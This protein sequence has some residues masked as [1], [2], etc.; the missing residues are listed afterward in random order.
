MA[1]RKL[2][3]GVTAYDSADAWAKETGGTYEIGADG[4]AYA[5]PAPHGFLDQFARFAPY[6]IMA[7]MG[8]GA[9]S[10]AGALG[11]AA[12][13]GSGVAADVASTMAV[14]GTVGTGS[15]IGG[16]MAS[17]LARYGIPMAGDFLTSMF[18]TSKD[19]KENQK[20]RDF[21]AQQNEL[22]RLR[23]R[24][25]DQQ[26]TAVDESKLDP[27]RNTMSQV[28][29]ASKLDRLS[30]STYTPVQVSR[31]QGGKIQTSG[32]TTYNKSPE[33]IAAARAAAALILSGGGQAPSMTDPAN[34]GKT[35]VTDLSGGGRGN[36]TPPGR[37]PVG[38]PGYDSSGINDPTRSW[39][40][41]P[42]TGLRKPPQL[43]T[44]GQYVGSADDPWNLAA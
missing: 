16:M 35:G 25:H 12:G 4:N 41:D 27:W 21:Y 13:G 2:P 6:G 34:Y 39:P 22:D 38:P 44:P 40:I 28:G 9:L 8:Y 15:A 5:T 36:I 31:G 1:T 17:P 32:G 42:A 19:A 43:R 29:N 18:S 26:Q 37:Q 7:G 24:E 23:Q 3:H 11:G 20:Q 14:P 33:L 30:G 10:G